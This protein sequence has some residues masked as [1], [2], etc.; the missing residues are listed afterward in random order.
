MKKSLTIVLTLAVG[1]TVGMMLGSKLMNRPRP[2][3]NPATL[4]GKP[5]YGAWK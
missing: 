5:I 2:G 4:I 3:A 1:L